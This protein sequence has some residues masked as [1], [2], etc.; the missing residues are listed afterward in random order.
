VDESVFDAISAKAEAAF[1]AEQV[2]KVLRF[3]DPAQHVATR[4]AQYM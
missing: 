3:C 4:Y 1:T 2:K